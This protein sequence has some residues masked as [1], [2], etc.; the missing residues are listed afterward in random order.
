MPTTPQI[1]VTNQQTAMSVDAERLVT[2][3]RSILVDH[4]IVRAQVS[5]AVV[6]DPTIHVLN[7]RYLAHDYPTDVLSFVLE[8]SDD[9]LEGEIVVSADTA[10][11]AAR[12]YGWEPADELLLYVVHGVLHLVGMDDQ[13]EE[14]RA[15]M[16]DVESRYLRQCGLTRRA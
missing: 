6:D 1:D 15:A 8:R 2:I 11:T 14:A 5:I 10:R 13:S 12:E 3:A 16:A 7:R 9:W 4:G